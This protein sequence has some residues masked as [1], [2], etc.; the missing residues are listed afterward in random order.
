MIWASD[1]YKTDGT[2][3]K[4]FS[5]WSVPK[6]LRDKYNIID[7][8]YLVINGS[9]SDFEFT[10]TYKITSGGEFRVSKYISQLIELKTISSNENIINFRIDIALKKADEFDKKVGQSLSESSY[11]RENRLINA[12]KVPT[13]RTVTSIVFNRNPD[14]VAEVLFRANGV[15]EICKNKAPFI[16][17][18]DNTP[19]L[20]VHHKIRLADGGEDT[21]KNAIAVCPNCHREKHFGI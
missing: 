20:E 9:I 4:Q 8:L 1:L 13:C 6:K 21:V 11:Q 7:G 14:V 16:R 17:K 19:Y 2:I 3:R 18:S 10:N 5:T 15:C 12:K